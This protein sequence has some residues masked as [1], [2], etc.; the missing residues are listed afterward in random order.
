MYLDYFL[1]NYFLQFYMHLKLI[2]QKLKKTYLQRTVLMSGAYLL[3]WYVLLHQ[4]KC[5]KLKFTFTKTHKDQCLQKTFKIQVKNY[6]IKF[7]Y[8]LKWANII[9][10]KPQ[11]RV[12]HFVFF[13][14]VL[15]KI[16]LIFYSGK[17]KATSKIHIIVVKY[18]LLY[19]SGFRSLYTIPKLW[20]WSKARASS[21]R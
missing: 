13:Y 10:F 9:S 8:F 18:I 14:K 11:I 6:D 19:F 20:R 5:W 7:C 12:L 1:Q 17:G 15:T 21:A 16:V 2:I 3:T 4:A